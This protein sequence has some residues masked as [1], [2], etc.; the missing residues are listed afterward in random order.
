L[1]VV[2]NAQQKMPLPPLAGSSFQKSVSLTHP[3]GSIFDET[4]APVVSRGYRKPT[5]SVVCYM[6]VGKEKGGMYTLR[7][8]ER[9]RHQ[10]RLE[11]RNTSYD[12]T[13][14][15]RPATTT[16]RQPPGRSYLPGSD[17][18]LR[19]R[20]FDRRAREA[21]S[22]G[23]QQWLS[24][25]GRSNDEVR[26]AARFGIMLDRRAETAYTSPPIGLEMVEGS[27]TPSWH[28]SRAVIKPGGF[29]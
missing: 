2:R 27:Y 25:N 9:T 14:S 22:E 20:N 6:Q 7:P 5:P 3:F 18:Y 8:H 11:L 16:L 29:R 19:G 15:P 12:T 21:A 13:F 1:V 23:P 26:R 17:P 28:N 10:R 24:D 4:I